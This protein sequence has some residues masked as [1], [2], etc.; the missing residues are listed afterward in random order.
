MT[1]VSGGIVVVL[2]ENA[3]EMYCFRF[4]LIVDMHYLRSLVYCCISLFSCLI[5]FCGV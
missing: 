1:E 3:M 2:C 4:D 5:T